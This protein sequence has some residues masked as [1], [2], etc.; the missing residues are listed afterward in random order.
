MD[1]QNLLTGYPLCT[2][3][4]IRSK[5]KKFGDHHKANDE[6]IVLS[7]ENGQKSHLGPKLWAFE[8]PEVY[9]GFWNF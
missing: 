9:S 3:A 8:K 7:T 4:Q 5:F 2:A 1:A 6:T